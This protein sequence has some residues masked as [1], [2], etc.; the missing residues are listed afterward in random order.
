MI[1]NTVVMTRARFHELRQRLFD[2]CF[3]RMPLRTGRCRCASVSA[4]PSSN[5]CARAAAKDSRNR[6]G[7]R[8]EGLPQLRVLDTRV[9]LVLLRRLLT[10]SL[11]PPSLSLSFTLSHS[12]SLPLSL[13][14]SRPVN[15]SLA[16]SLAI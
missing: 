12:L 15:F 8:F 5:G 10:Q 6:S 7:N 9:G 14:L 3:S 2:L 13:S 11:S 1:I 4:A 16:H